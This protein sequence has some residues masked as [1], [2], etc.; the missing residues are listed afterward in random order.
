MRELTLAF[1]GQ[2]GKCRILST[3][4]NSKNTVK[5]VGKQTNHQNEYMYVLQV[6]FIF[7]FGYVQ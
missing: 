3:L 7:R 1:Q 4:T 6:L 2:M 5:L